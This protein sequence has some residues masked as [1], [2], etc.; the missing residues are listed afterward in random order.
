MEVKDYKAMDYRFTFVFSMSDGDNKNVTVC[1]RDFSINNFDQESLR[2]IELKECM[3]DIVT[4]ID[5]D[6][7]SKTRTL[8]WNTMNLENHSTQVVHG[9]DESG[10]S[11]ERDF[12]EPI[13]TERDVVLKVSLLDGGKEVI[14]KIWSGNG[15]PK[16]ILWSKN[17]LTQEVSPNIDLTNKKYKY[18]SINTQSLDFVKQVAQRAAS[19]KSDLTV[20]I[21]NHISSVCSSSFSKDGSG[22]KII[23]KQDLPELAYETVSDIMGD[24]RHINNRL[25]PIDFIENDGRAWGFDR[26]IFE[27][28]TNNVNYGS[29]NYDLSLT[30]QE[31]W[32]D[33][34][35]TKKRL[36]SLKF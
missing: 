19:D 24:M 21:K 16:A 35:E 1:K 25:E 29:K 32:I 12:N 33:D 9:S 31:K 30:P 8:L 5:K 7:K 18:D 11:I 36:N 20:T 15:Y 23:C 14:S 4:M 2:S 34:I 3:D 13:S 6:L 27:A 17:Y 28:Y 26:A 22:K 10:K